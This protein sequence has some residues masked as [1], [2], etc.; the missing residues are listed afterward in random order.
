MAL[1]DRLML[2]PIRSIYLENSHNFVIRF[3]KEYFEMSLR[4]GEGLAFIVS[5]SLCLHTSIYYKLAKN[6]SIF[7]YSQ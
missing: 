3:K 5:D 1:T 2:Q 7:L 4:F 6:A